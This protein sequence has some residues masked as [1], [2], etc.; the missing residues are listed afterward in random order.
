MFIKQ[1]IRNRIKIFKEK[2]FNETKNKIGTTVIS[3]AFDNGGG[4]HPGNLTHAHTQHVVDYGM[5]FSQTM[6]DS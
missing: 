6:I 4:T 2:K 5:L 1:R 3:S